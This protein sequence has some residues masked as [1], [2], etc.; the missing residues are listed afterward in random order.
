MNQQQP[1]TLTLHLTFDHAAWH[2]ARFEG[3]SPAS[4]D[5]AAAR[6]LLEHPRLVAVFDE[7]TRL[8]QFPLT[9]A[10]AFTGTAIQIPTSIE[11]QEF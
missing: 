9:S 5:H 3:E 1:T 4:V 11:L 6:W 2:T 10:V 7:H 8:D